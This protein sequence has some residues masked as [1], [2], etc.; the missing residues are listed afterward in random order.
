M[1]LLDKLIFKEL[2]PPFFFGVFAFSILFFAGDYLL[3]LT[4]FISDGVPVITILKM[5]GYYMPSVVYYTLPMA[6]LLS[7]IFAVGRISG[8]SEMTAMF[9]GGISYKRILMPI[10]AFVIMASLFSYLLNDFVAPRCFVELN[11]LEKEIENNMAPQTR[12]ITIYDR[13][14]RTL[15]RISGGFDI[16]RGIIKD[17]TC[18][19]FNEDNTPNLIVVAKL[20][21]WQGLNDDSKKFNW[22]LYNGYSQ[23]LGDDFSAKMSFDKT[24]TKE[25]TIKKDVKEIKLLQK[26]GMKSSD[27]HMNF[28]ELKELLAYYK[29]SPETDKETLNKTAVFMWNR[30]ALPLSCFILGMIAAPLAIRSHRGSAGVGIGISLLVI[31]VYYIVWNFGSNMAYSG[32]IPPFLGSFGG[33]I[34]GI[35]FGYYFNNRVN[36]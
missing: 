34:L 4:A 28:W 31:L 19:Q 5:I 35:M 30:F 9:A 24:E 8:E 29:R 10:L 15:I 23:K 21:E 12:P 13:D 20:A 26:A 32:T 11:N 36:M 2:I 3:K 18:I 33:D 27:T 17:L 14:T 7:V 22:K 1:R 16:K 25:I 6:T